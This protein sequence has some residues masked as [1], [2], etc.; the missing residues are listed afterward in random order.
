MKIRRLGS[1]AATLLVAVL[2]VAHLGACG[3]PTTLP[4]REANGTG[5]SIAMEGVRFD[6]STRIASGTVLV[7]NETGIAG[8]GSAPT[9]LV[10]YI[11]PAMLRVTETPVACTPTLA[12]PTTVKWT[13]SASIPEGFAFYGVR[14][15]GGRYTNGRSQSRTFDSE[16]GGFGD[17]DRIP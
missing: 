8:I 3:G 2:F 12:G 14:L 13:F 9:F 10:Q 17:L 16:L 1:R 11:D 5:A 7:T 4:G 15:V 6:D